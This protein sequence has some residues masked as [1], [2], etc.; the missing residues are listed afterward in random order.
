MSARCRQPRPHGVLVRVGVAA[1]AA[2]GVVGCSTP[3]QAVPEP[4]PTSATAT[5]TVVTVVANENSCDVTPTHV[6]AGAVTMVA[7][8]RTG[9]SG[10]VT[11][12]AP[13]RGAFTLVVATITLNRPEATRKTTVDLPIGAYEVACSVGTSERR[14]RLTSV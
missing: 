6:P 2:I 4:T 7:S 10:L 3:D 9:T 11:V 13:S 12:Y 8:L 14:S 5:A 1:A